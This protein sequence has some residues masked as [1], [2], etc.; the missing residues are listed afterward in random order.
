MSDIADIEEYA[1]G[2]ELMHLS[3]G[4]ALRRYRSAVIH[5]APD[6]LVVLEDHDCGHWGVAEYSTPEE[7]E[8]YF[9]HLLNKYVT[10][11]MS[12]LSHAK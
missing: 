8:V 2:A 11:F 5:K 3:E 12:A 1:Y 7:R 9:K 10:L 6:S 4:E